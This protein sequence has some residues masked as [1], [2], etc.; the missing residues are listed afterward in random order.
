MEL[1]EVEVK[2]LKMHELYILEYF[3]ELCKKNN[4]KYSL[5]YGTL[6]GAIRHNGF[7]PWDDDIDVAMPRKD[8]EILCS[9]LKKENNSNF[10]LQT[11]ETE[12]NYYYTFAKLRL[13]NTIFK[14]DRTSKLN[15]NQGIF[16]DI[17]PFDNVPSNKRLR[18]RINFK[19]RLYKTIIDSKIIKIKTRHGL[20]KIIAFFFRLFFCWLKLQN[21][22]NKL[23][24]I[25]KKT[26]SIEPI[27]IKN[28]YCFKKHEN[29]YFPI[30][31]FENLDR[32]I[33]ENRDFSIIKEYDSFL[34]KIYGNYME[35]PPLS[36]RTNTHPILEIKFEDSII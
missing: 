17:F 5:I 24:K 9:I 31:M 1:S 36:Q 2:K 33:F 23:D 30:N 7:I 16:I 6:I 25:L 21:A 14:E 34:K 12:K 8:F 26:N 18:K 32:H 20:N 27:G 22:H 15:I 13:N 35:L 10:F 28:Y 11:N 29:L 4:L 19:F 3:D